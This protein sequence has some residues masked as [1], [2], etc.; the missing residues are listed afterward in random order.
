MFNFNKHIFCD[1]ILYNGI[2]IY[3]M[4]FLFFLTQITKTSLNP[5][6]M[7]FTSCK[8]DASNT[9]IS[10]LLNSTRVLFK[11]NPPP[12][13]VSDNKN[14]YVLLENVLFGCAS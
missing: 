14:K 4:F 6:F 8:T 7:G 11:N 9:I 5:V 2:H 12:S 10:D 1:F 3:N 13:N